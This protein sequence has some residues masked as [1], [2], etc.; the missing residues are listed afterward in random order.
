MVF[1]RLP[2]RAIRIA[3]N[4]RRSSFLRLSKNGSEPHNLSMT[5]LSP[6]TTPRKTL[7]RSATSN[8]SRVVVWSNARRDGQMAHSS[9]VA[10]VGAVIGCVVVPGAGLLIG[11]FIGLIIGALLSSSEDQRIWQAFIAAD[12]E[13]AF[14]R[15]PPRFPTITPV[16]YQP[17]VQ[18][19]E[20]KSYDREAI[21]KR[22]CYTCQNCDKW[23]QK[24]WELEVHH[25]I[26]RSKGGSDDPTNL[27]TLCV[28]CHDRETWFGHIRVHPTTLPKSKPFRTSF[29]R[30]RYH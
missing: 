9:A 27:V 18:I 23:K 17:V 3:S 1:R 30:R 2:L 29:Y 8:G 4:A 12:P 19:T 7:L 11:G 22:D 28:E 10:I 20:A 15:Q 25:V 24:K 26:P 5:S 14:T 21:L 16:K 13:P 6:H